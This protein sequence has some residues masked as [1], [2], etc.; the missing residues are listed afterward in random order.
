[1]STRRSFLFILLFSVAH[2]FHHLLTSI[3]VPLLPMIR[4]DFS[5][6]YAQAGGV[7]SA[8]TIAYGLAQLPAGWVADRVGARY[9]LFAGVSGVA[10]VG[11]LIGFSSSYMGLLILLAV[12][13]VMGGG[14]HPSAA[15]L[16]SAS[17]EPSR[18]GKALGMHI[19]GGSASHFVSP[20]AAVALA[21]VIGWRG[22]FLAIA[23]PVFIFG[24]ILFILLKLYQVT[25]AGQKGNAKTIEEPD[26]PRPLVEIV[27]YLVVS[28]AIGAVAGSVIA[29]VPLFGVDGLGA[30]RSVSAVFLSLYF[31]SGMVFAPL[32][33]GI[34][35]KLGPR[36]VFGILAVLAGPVVMLLSL[37][38]HWIML[39]LIMVV[40]GAVMFTR[41][42]VSETYFVTHVPKRWRSTVLGI[43]YFAGM[44]ASGILTPLLGGAIDVWGFSA[45][46]FMI[47]AVLTA[48]ALISL[49]VLYGV[50][51]RQLLHS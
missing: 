44:E 14:Y 26:E 18:R 16:V 40:L 33:G 22:S 37:V 51:R 47:G 11:I 4:D 31:L 9:L 8:F 48:V 13:G 27:V 25:A 50:S 36:S 24:I 39:A 17:V 28:S 6:S 49:A 34:A 20:L 35:D 32:S 38:Q 3:I 7:A 29:F 10:V 46:F 45:S 21:G 23:V 15:P 19:V 43:Y 12:L 42:V 1:M 5:L 30:S 41:M 2:F